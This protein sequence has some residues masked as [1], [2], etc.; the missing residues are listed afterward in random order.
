[1]ASDV[2]PDGVTLLDGAVLLA[3]LR[4]SPSSRWGVLLAPRSARR[5]R[6]PIRTIAKVDLFTAA[7]VILGVSGLVMVAVA[8]WVVT[9]ALVLAAEV[10]EHRREGVTR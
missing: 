8:F 3:E 7:A 4:C 5:L 9:L 1:M 10:A 2:R 6:Y